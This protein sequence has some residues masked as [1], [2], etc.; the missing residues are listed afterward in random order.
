PRSRQ[1]VARRI[2]EERRRRARKPTAGDR[3]AR[4][5]GP[6][7]A[8]QGRFEAASRRAR[9]C[10]GLCVAQRAGEVARSDPA[11]ASLGNREAGARLA[12]T[13]RAWALGGDPA[14]AGG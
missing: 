10:G 8:R 1:D 13:S 11:A 14:P 6:R 12:Y 3:R 4:Q 5:T 7:V 2:P 9:A